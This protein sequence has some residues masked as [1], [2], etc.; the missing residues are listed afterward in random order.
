MRA[1]SWWQDRNLWVVLAVGLVLRLLM[2]LPVLMKPEL[3]APAYGDAIGYHRLAVNLLHGHGF[4]IYPSPPFAPD[5]FRTPGFP[6]LL[7]FIYWVF[8]P[9]PAWGVLLNCLLS[10]A[11]PALVY[12][13]AK[14]LWPERGLLA[15]LLYA[16]NPLSLVYAPQIMTETSFTLAVLLGF[17]LMTPD[18]RPVRW[19]SRT[20]RSRI[21]TRKRALTWSLAGAFTVGVAA[22][23]RPVGLVLGPVIPFATGKRWLMGI[24][25]FLV[26]VGLWVLRNQLV[27]GIPFFSTVSWVNLVY[28]NAAAVLS[29]QQHI[30]LR[31]AD[32]QVFNTS[33]RRFGW[34]TVAVDE[35]DIWAFEE[36]PVKWRQMASVGLEIILKDPGTYALEHAKGLAG[37]LAPV[38]PYRLPAVYGINPFLSGKR[39]GS[40]PEV[41]SKL[42]RQGPRALLQDIFRGLP[43]WAGWFWGFAWIYQLI[44]FALAGVALWR[45]RRCKTAWLLLAAGV[46]LFAVAGPMAV[47]RMRHT[48]DALF[49]VLAGGA[50]IP[51]RSSAH[52]R[53]Q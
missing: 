40:G 49:A 4:S 16:F 23:I 53:D 47:P 22:L 21:L 31:Q 5:A 27:F 32:I 11:T 25:S 52:N 38:H 42:L 28:Y 37:A 10:G 9:N 46:L 34:D 12:L 20:G 51:R 1:R 33:S 15:G 41:I 50:L 26:P 30:T 14:Q 45:N 18:S 17:A 43:W 7:A 36:D 19:R 13:L 8:G 6:A 24:A 44:L 39:V 48:T 29:A 35:A 2:T 3:S